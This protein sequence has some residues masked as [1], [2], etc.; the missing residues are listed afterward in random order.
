MLTVGLFVLSLLALGQASPSEIQRFPGARSAYVEGSLNLAVGER[1]TLRRSEDGSYTLE[2]VERIEFHEVLPPRAGSRPDDPQLN[3]APAGSLRFG[4]HAR[5]DVGSVLKVENGTED[6]LKY[7]G[8][9]VRLTGG[10]SR[11][12]IE[13]SVCTVPASLISFEHWPEPVT[14]VVIGGLERSEDRVPTCPPH[15]EEPQRAAPPAEPPLPGEAPTPALAAEAEQLGRWSTLIALCESYY[16]VDIEAMNSVAGD[17]ERR[18]AEAGWTRQQRQAAYDAGR[19]RERA[20]V[21]LILDTSGLAPRE[22][23]RLYGQMLSR[24]KPRCHDLAQGIPGSVSDLEGGDRKLD[25][26]RRSFR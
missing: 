8:F 16:A 13:T 23:R 21:G 25:A 14:Q 12:P 7:S 10:Q 24:L 15:I 2:Q 11:G 19:V 22:A 26:E 3:G 9:I 6:G 18:S 4:L 17:F 5:R 1:A 20:E